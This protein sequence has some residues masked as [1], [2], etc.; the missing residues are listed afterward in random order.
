MFKV[1]KY[2]KIKL[3]CFPNE[4]SNKIVST[5]KKNTKKLFT[6]KSFEFKLKQPK[7]WA[8]P[9]KKLGCYEKIK[10]I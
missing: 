3:K 6:N 4:S 9:N 2:N 5:T 1:T 7:L 10:I 8:R